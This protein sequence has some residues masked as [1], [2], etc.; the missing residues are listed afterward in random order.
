MIGG[1]DR[2]R[3]DDLHNAIVALFQLSYGPA[4]SVFNVGLRNGRDKTRKLDYSSLGFFRRGGRVSFNPLFFDFPVFRERVG[5]AG[6]PVLSPG[7]SIFSPGFGFIG[8]CVNPT[9]GVGGLS[10]SACGTSRAVGG[11]SGRS[12]LSSSSP[13]EGDGT[14]GESGVGGLGGAESSGGLTLKGTGGGSGEGSD[15]SCSVGSSPKDGGGGRSKGMGSGIDSSCDPPIEGGGANHRAQN[16]LLQRTGT[17]V[18]A[19]RGRGEQK[20]PPPRYYFR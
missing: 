9:G 3:T 8:G 12:E 6:L 14:G 2:V 17:G 20:N 16:L 18:E 5:L 4:F 13:K 10:T 11:A 7:F 19:S 15:S 1:A